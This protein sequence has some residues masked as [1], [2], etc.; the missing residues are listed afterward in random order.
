MRRTR[1]SRSGTLSVLC[2]NTQR[3]EMGDGGRAPGAAG[4]STC[5]V[6]DAGAAGVAPPL[7]L[8]CGATSATP[9]R[10]GSEKMRSC[11]KRETGFFCAQLVGDATATASAKKR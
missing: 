5:M 1:A 8:S 4:S 6:R 3:R 11:Y 9:G 2:A 10:K 7:K